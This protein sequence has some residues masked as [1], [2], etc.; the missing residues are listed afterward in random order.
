MAPV[1]SNMQDSLHE[2]ETFDAWRARWRLSG[3]WA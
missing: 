2:S 3:H 1:A